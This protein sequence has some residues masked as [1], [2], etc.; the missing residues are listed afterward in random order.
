MGKERMGQS[1]YIHFNGRTMK[2]EEAIEMWR[3]QGIPEHEIKLRK[4]VASLLRD[5]MK[6]R[7]LCTRRP[8]PELR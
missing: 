3:K 2:A 1:L 8:P 7:P 4:F 5:E 6:G